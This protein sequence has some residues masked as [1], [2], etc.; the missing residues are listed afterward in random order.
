MKGTYFMYFFMESMKGIYFMH[1]FMESMK[2][3]HF[4]HFFMESMKGTYLC[5]LSWKV[6]QKHFI[7]FFMESMKGQLNDLN[8]RIDILN[9]STEDCFMRDYNGLNLSH[10][11]DFRGQGGE[12]MR[13]AGMF[14]TQINM[15]E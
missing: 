10:Y 13:P 11:F 1:F 9:L 4:M 7:H 5:I 6:S 12:L 8:Y 14:G 2:G 15:S 3:I